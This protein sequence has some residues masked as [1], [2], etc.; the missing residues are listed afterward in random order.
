MATLGA[1]GMV[2][3]VDGAKVGARTDTTFGQSYTGYWRVGGDNLGGWPGQPA[4]NYLNGQIDDVAVYPTVLTSAK[5]RQHY[6]SAGYT[7]AGADP[8]GRRL[9]CRG[10]RRGA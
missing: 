9:R 7:L 2:L 5:V 10:V 3:Y 8:A 4:S 6:L 1:N